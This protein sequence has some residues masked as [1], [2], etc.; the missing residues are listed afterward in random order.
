MTTRSAVDWTR[1]LRILSAEHNLVLTLTAL[2]GFGLGLLWRQRWPIIWGV[3][4][5]VFLAIMSAAE[6][7][8]P[9]YYLLPIV[10][11]LW[12]LSSQAIVILSRGRGWLAV[13]GLA[14][15]T[16]VPLSAVVRQNHE[17]TKLDT[18][19]VAKEWIEANIPAGAKIL[20]DGYQNRFTP[21][22][23]LTP[24]RSAVLRQ[25]VGVSSEPDRF[26]AVSQKTLKLYAEAMRTAEGPTYDLHSTVWG[27]AV[28]EPT[29]Y[30][31]HCF[32][33]VITSSS[34]TNRYISEINRKRFPRSAE[35]YEQLNKH[36]DFQR[37]YSVEPVSWQRSGPSIAVY[38]VNSSCAGSSS[39]SSVPQ[40]NHFPHSE[41]Y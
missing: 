28:E 18:R 34:I 12:L 19:V 29:Y 1:Y 11:C 41:P 6:V 32:E 8:Q 38:K 3:Y 25:I 4:S 35:F 22:P 17:W 15:V 26:R 2:A 14:C 40:N 39:K 36:P 37:I 13:T 20:M 24:D 31:T 7:S 30:V 5:A 9:E 16:V 27:L 10:P 23:P 33:Y 21:S